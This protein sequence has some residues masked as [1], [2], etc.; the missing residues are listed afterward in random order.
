MPKNPEKKEWS[1]LSDQE[2]RELERELEEE[3]KKPK[4]IGWEK[5]EKRREELIEK[6]IDKREDEGETKLE[7]ES[8]LKEEKEKLD[9][10]YKEAKRLPEKEKRG[11][12]V[13]EK[14]VERLMKEKKEEFLSKQRKLSGEG[15]SAAE[16]YNLTRNF[17]L[18][19]LGYDLKYKGIL[20]GKARVWD[21]K[22]GKYLLDKKTGKPIE[23]KASFSPKGETPFLKFLEEEYKKKI[24][25]GLEKT[26]EEIK[27]RVKKAEIPEE[28]SVTKETKEGAETVGAREEKVE[29]AKK[30]LTQAEFFANYLRV[31]GL[32]EKDLAQMPQKLKE[33]QQ[34]W[35]VYQKEIGVEVPIEVPEEK[36]IETTK[37][38]EREK[39]EP[40]K[41]E[42]PEK[43]EK[44]EKKEISA[45]IKEKLREFFKGIEKDPRIEKALKEI[46]AGNT[47]L[48]EK[49]LSRMLRNSKRNLE[50]AKEKNN[51]K[52]I[53]EYKKHIEKL[54]GF[55]REIKTLLPKEKKEITVEKLSKVIETAIRKGNTKEIELNKKEKPK[56]KT[57]W[58]EKGIK[59]IEKGGIPT[60]I[61]KE[62]EQYLTKNEIS[63]DE[64]KKMKP[65]EAWEK[66]K[67]IYE[68]EKGKTEEK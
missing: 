15:L 18:G 9:K 57:D 52:L 8:Q 50:M 2:K 54:N 10:I 43:E 20:R 48:A 12:E 22:E 19:E 38:P 30:P 31:T 64:I 47:E 26:A 1:Q 5:F 21:R 66:A 36:K 67:K 28:V 34:R 6:T 25:E 32:S 4:E 58:L 61:S 13:I 62:L 27:E 68:K 45:S 11:K 49:E 37:V 55:L 44:P 42:K 24:R 35:E 46:M 23:F 59:S 3:E 41:A 16:I 14:E 60:L 63:E 17:Y 56:E 65:A 33:L 51:Q 7:K 39:K 40:L 29:P 53:R